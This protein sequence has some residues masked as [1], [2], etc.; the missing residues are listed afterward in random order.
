MRWQRADRAEFVLLVNRLKEDVSS[1]AIRAQLRLGTEAEL[2]DRHLAE[3][4][5]QK[6]LYR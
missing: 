5:E 6:S 4:I 1:T 3:Y 2:L